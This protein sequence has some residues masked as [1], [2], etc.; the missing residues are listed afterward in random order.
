MCLKY[1]CKKK[2]EEILTTY[3]IILGIIKYDFDWIRYF[4]CLVA[5]TDFKTIL[6]P[7]IVYPYEGS[8]WYL[9]PWTILIKGKS[10]P[11]AFAIKLYLII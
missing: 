9:Y 7:K 1:I 10:C 8:L 2:V 11:C 3:A 5:W 4:A 6:V